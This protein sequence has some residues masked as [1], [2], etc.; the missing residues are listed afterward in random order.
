MNNLF[1]DVRLAVADARE[2]WKTLSF[3]V[4]RSVMAGIAALVAFFFIAWRIAVPLAI[5]AI[6][7]VSYLRRS[8]GRDSL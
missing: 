1:E 4:R 7:V 5:F 8:R 3:E 6:L 2:R